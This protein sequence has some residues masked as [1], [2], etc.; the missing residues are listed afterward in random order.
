VKVLILLIFLVLQINAQNSPIVNDLN[1][2]PFNDLDIPL[3]ND[4]SY[5]ERTVN[6]VKL[7]PNTHLE[8]LHPYDM[9]ILEFKEET[10]S[11]HEFL[12]ANNN[13][14]EEI[15]L[16]NS[17]NCYEDW[18]NLGNKWIINQDG[19]TTYK[20]SRG[21]R[22]HIVNHIPHSNMSQVFYIMHK[23]NVQSLGFLVS[24][25][26]PTGIGTTMVKKDSIYTYFND[27]YPKT[28]VEIIKTDT[29][30]PPPDPDDPDFP[31]TGD[32]DVI[33]VTEYVY[34]TIVCGTELLTSSIESRKDTLTNGL[35]VRIIT[36]NYY[37]NYS[38]DCEDIILPRNQDENQN[39]DNAKFYENFAIYPNP[40][41]DENLILDVPNS[42]IDNKIEITLKTINGKLIKTFI[43]PKAYK[44]MT[45]NA[46]NYLKTQGIYIITIKNDKQILSKKFYF[47]NK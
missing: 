4:L 3:V 45:L 20:D 44:Q 19:I 8:D 34:D 12:D 2:P 32:P 28:V 9:P 6:H 24:K 47:F 17:V 36:E 10:N 7:P 29:F 13:P 18:E 15:T 40:L 33:K 39:K 11:H 5:V 42:F 46:T 38:L 26:Y 22:G 27:T 43:I 30:S 31:F 1:S 25:A 35:C 21:S 37:T 16:L 41:Q 23:Q 14:Q